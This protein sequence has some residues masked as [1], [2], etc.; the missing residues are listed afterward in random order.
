[1]IKP[2]A[3]SPKSSFPAPVCATQTSSAGRLRLGKQ[4]CLKL[5]FNWTTFWGQINLFFGFARKFC[6]LSSHLVAPDE[7]KFVARKDNDFSLNRYLIEQADQ[8]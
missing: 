8:F 2:I 7:F 3:L 4:L 1:V 5:T 6:A